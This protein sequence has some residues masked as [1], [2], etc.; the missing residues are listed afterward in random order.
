MF[1]TRTNELSRPGENAFSLR[2]SCL[3]GLRNILPSSS[4]RSFAGGGTRPYA[5]ASATSVS[6]QHLS[7]LSSENT[8]RISG[9]GT[10]AIEP[11]SSPSVGVAPSALVRVNQPEPCREFLV[12]LLIHGAMPRLCCRRIRA[13]EVVTFPVC[14]RPYGLRREATPA[15]RA[16]VFQNRL[17]T[18]PAKRTLE[19]A[20]HCLRGVGSQF[21]TAIFADWPE[22]EHWCIRFGGNSCRHG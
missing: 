8:A 9:G 1:R 5:T 15:I 18:Y 7:R 22:F 17:D 19:T 20:D 4:A 2:W 13:E 16:H 14:G 21:P 11:T 12:R 10:G 3:A 6:T